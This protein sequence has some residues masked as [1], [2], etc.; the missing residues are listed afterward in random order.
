MFD[1]RAGNLEFTNSLAMQG[2]FVY[3]NGTLA[4]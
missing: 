4:A 3:S 1:I 2:S